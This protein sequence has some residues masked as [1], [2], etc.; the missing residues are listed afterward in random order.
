[1]SFHS[2]SHAI[3]DGEN[4]S[5]A[6]MRMEFLTRH[7]MEQDTSRT[8]ITSA[9]TSQESYFPLP[10][11]LQSLTKISVVLSDDGREMLKLADKEVYIGKY[12]RNELRIQGRTVTWLAQQLC[13]KRSSLYYHFRQDSIDLEL[14]KRISCILEHNFIQDMAEDS[15]PY[16]L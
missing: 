12:I 10:D 13:V 5:P 15:K 8:D 9:F 16:G 2:E 1:M 14:L 3:T 11:D 4:A 6:K 7:K